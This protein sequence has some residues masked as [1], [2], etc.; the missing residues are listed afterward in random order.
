M[1]QELDRALPSGIATQGRV[2]DKRLIDLKPDRQDRIQSRHGLLEDH[3]DIGAAHAPQARRWH[4][5]QILAAPENA[6]RHASI[7]V[8]DPRD[9]AEREAAALAARVATA[10]DIERVNA[11]LKRM[12]RAERGED[13]T[14]ESDIAAL[15]ITGERSQ[16][17]NG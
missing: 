1:A 17:V 7:G 16:P 2:R 10:D 13:D 14:L 3:R 12:E 9:R 6:P 5:Q 15:A 11:G 4:R 8:Q